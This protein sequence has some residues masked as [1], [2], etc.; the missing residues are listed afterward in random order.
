MAS[1]AQVESALRAAIADHQAGRTEAAFIAY[2]R[3]R[4]GGL[5]DFRVFHLGGTA[6][7]QLERPSEAQEWLTAAARLSPRVAATRM[8]LGLALWHSGSLEAAERELR[9]AAS[10]ESGNAEIWGNL[11]LFLL[12]QTRAEEALACLQRATAADPTRSQPWIQLGRTQNALSQPAGALASFDRAL[13]AEPGSSAALLGRGQALYALGRLADALASFEACLRLDPGR[14][15]AASQRLL[16]LNYVDNCD[17]AAVA[18]AHIEFGLRAAPPS[19]HVPARAPASVSQRLR[20]AFLSPDLRTHP[21]PTFLQPL[22]THA[23]AES[24]EILLYHDHFTEDAV[25]ARL[26]VRAAVWRNFHGRSDRFV[27]ETVRADRP[28]ILVDLAGHTG[29]NRMPLLAR[30]LAPV[31]VTYLGYPNT[32]GL[33][34]MDFRFTDAVAD[35]PGTTDAWHTERLIRFSDTAWCFRPPDGAPPVVDPPLARGGA[36]PVFGSFN[37]PAKLSPSTLRLWARLLASLPGASLI[38][39]APADIGSLLNAF[40]EAGAPGGA[41]SVAPYFSSHHEHLRAYG[42]IDVA[43]DP[44]PYNGTTTT[45][46]A[47]WMGRPVVTLAGSHHCARVG[48][49]L[50][51]AIGET[52]C[53]AAGAEEYLAI[54]RRLVADPAT[55]AERVRSLRPRVSASLLTDA[56]TQ[57]GRFWRALRDCAASNLR[58]ASPSA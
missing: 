10:L 50:L 39:K 15:E 25:S 5:K 7:L 12:A 44:F 47:L 35:P 54:C 13:A 36:A 48:A 57:A 27:A 43:L 32:T 37:N 28:D 38:V 20:V 29:F 49:S 53:I 52:D 8:C 55:L 30:R 31:Q 33:T 58:P 26:R 11:G 40:L 22:L 46:E 41:V 17:P 45:C 14:L 21:V 23:P 19:A 56:P 9:L 1:F 3:L 6:L 42:G 24:V 34:A 4:K 16:L 18:R 2:A 51:T